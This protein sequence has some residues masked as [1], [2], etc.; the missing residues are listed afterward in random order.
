VK[1]VTQNAASGE[2]SSLFEQHRRMLP[3]R[4]WQSNIELMG[5]PNG[6][7]LPATDD[8]LNEENGG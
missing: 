1:G 7:F 4:S 6:C 5:F 8:R 2:S 3:W